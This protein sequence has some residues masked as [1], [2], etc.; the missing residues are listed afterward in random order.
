MSDAFIKWKHLILTGTFAFQCDHNVHA[1]VKTAHILAHYYNTTESEI[2]TETKAFAKE[3]NWW[4]SQVGEVFVYKKG[5]SVKNYLKNIECYPVDELFLTIFARMKEIQIGVLMRDYYWTTAKQISIDKCEIILGFAGHYT[6]GNFTFPVLFD[7]DEYIVER[8]PPQPSP[9]EIVSEVAR[10]LA[11]LRYPA[12][13]AGIESNASGTEE[14]NN[15]DGVPS[16]TDVQSG[17][18]DNNDGGGGS[19]SSGTD[20]LLS[21]T[22][23]NNNGAGVSSGTDVQSGTEDNHDGGGGS[24][25]SGT[26]VPS[27]TEQ[28]NSH[29]DLPSGTAVPS[30]TEQHNSHGDLPSVTAVPSGNED[31][32][33]VLNGNSGITQEVITV[34]GRVTTRSARKTATTSGRKTRNS[35]NAGLGDALPPAKR[36]KCPKSLK[37]EDPIGQALGGLS[38]LQSNDDGT[39]D[40]ESKEH[41]SP[42]AKSIKTEGGQLK[43]TEHSIRRPQKKVLKLKCPI[44]GCDVRSDSEAARNKHLKD[45]HPD[46]SF[47]CDLCDKRFQTSNGLWKHKNKH[48]AAKFVCSWEDCKKKCYYK[49]DYDAHMKTHTKTGLFPCTWKGCDSAFVSTKNM[50]S[51]LES[52]NDVKHPCTQCESVFET[53]YNLAQHIRGKH[54]EDDDEGSLKSKCGQLFKWPENRAKHQASCDECQEYFTRLASLPEKPAKAKK[55]KIETQVQS[56]GSKD[57]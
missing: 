12:L 36:R 33:G 5:T 49:S 23:E 28:N 8:P 24:L 52:H 14:N 55:V 27:G 51:H 17:T 9:P 4:V 57:E 38:P 47:T 13:D 21:G 50:Y 46:H 40:E 16:G 29:G 1:G 30:G 53:K 3:N 42:P 31:N 56:D 54:T 22:E 11:T 7:T 34:P 45:S 44:S 32:N 20:V 6:E 2:L 26:A 18:E 41:K 10:V 25:S 35:L 15:G 48:Y 37:E 39:S 19:L 43:V